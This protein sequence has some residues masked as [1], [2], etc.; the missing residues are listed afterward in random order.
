MVGREV[1]EIGRDDMGGQD[2]LETKTITLSTILNESS[3]AVSSH[4]ASHF[5]GLLAGAKLW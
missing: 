3:E 5:D 4:N 1:L 2:I